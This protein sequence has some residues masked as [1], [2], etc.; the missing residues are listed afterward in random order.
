MDPMRVL[1]V[2]LGAQAERTGVAILEAE[3]GQLPKA[4]LVPGKATDDFLIARALEVDIIGID[5]P[6][7]WP[8]D[9]VAAISAHERLEPWLGMVDRSELCYR[10]TD[11]QVRMVTNKWPL[12][13]SADKLGIVA[14]RCALLQERMTAE[15]WQGERQ[16]RDGT[17]CLVEVYPASALRV[18]GLQSEGYK[19]A[20]TE[21][22]AVRVAIVQGLREVLDLDQVTD[23]CIASDDSLDAVISALVA[24]RSKQRRTILPSTEENTRLA[25]VEGWIHMPVRPEST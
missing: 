6:L 12:S 23:Q 4:R 25:K 10:A 19:G 9:F 21:K 5:A 16:P 22:T 3:P 8:V 17:G 20:G 2:D 15:V 11:H 18:W 1:G 14:M 13:V 7:G 24:L